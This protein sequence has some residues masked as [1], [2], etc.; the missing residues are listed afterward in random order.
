MKYVWGFAFGMW[1]CMIILHYSGVSNVEIKKNIQEDWPKSQYGQIVAINFVQEIKQS[2]GNP[3]WYAVLKTGDNDP[4]GVISKEKP[5]TGVFF[6]TNEGCLA[7][8]QMPE[9]PKPE[10]KPTETANQ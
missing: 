10:S 1:T 8:A 6:V 2:D 4:F 3:A 9:V 5:P 7:P